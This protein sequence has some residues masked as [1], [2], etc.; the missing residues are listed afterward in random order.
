MK[1]NKVYQYPVIDLKDWDESIKKEIECVHLEFV[2]LD[3]QDEGLEEL[4][5]VVCFK[6]K[7]KFKGEN[8]LRKKIERLL[9]TK[10]ILFYYNLPF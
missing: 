8:Q 3:M 6:A 1:K 5:F 7:E 4:Y 10:K 2:G 9:K